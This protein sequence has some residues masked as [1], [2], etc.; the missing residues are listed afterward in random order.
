LNAAICNTPLPEEKKKAIT[1]VFENWK[2]IEAPKEDAGTKIP[3][4][5]S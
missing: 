4:T 5:S 3:D 1:A 2:L